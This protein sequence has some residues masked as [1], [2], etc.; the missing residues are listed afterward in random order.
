MS[1]REKSAWITLVTV[2]ACFGIY[3]GSIVTGRVSGRDL[4]T[5]HLLLMCVIVLVVLQCAL[6]VIAAMTTPRDGRAPKDEREQLIQW[7]SHTLGYYVLVV[8]VLGLFIPGHLGH[9]VI[10][11]MNFALLDVVLAVL[12]VAVAQIVMFRRGA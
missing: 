5:L 6:T 11:M 8:L 1:F 9:T 4:D 3:F 2:L 7:R 12:T 10:D